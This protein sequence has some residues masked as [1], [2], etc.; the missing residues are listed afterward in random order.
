MRLKGLM[1]SLNLKS[2]DFEFYRF[3][4]HEEYRIHKHRAADEYQRR[5]QVELSLIRHDANCFYVDGYC[6]VCR[7]VTKFRVGFTYPYQNTADGKP[8]PDWREHLNCVKCGF[9][10]RVRLVLHLLQD[11]VRPQA[12]ARIYVTEQN[13]PVFKWLQSRYPQIMGSEYLGDS[14]PWGAYCHG[15]RNENLIR[16]SFA[17]KSFDLILSFDVMEHAIDDLSALSECFRCL[18]PGGTLVFTAPCNLESA[19]NVVR[20]Q[21]RSDG[22]IEHLMSPPE[23]HVNPAD[24]ENGALCFR[25]FGWEVIGQL[26]SVGFHDAQVISAWSRDL[27]YLGGEQIVFVATKGTV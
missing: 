15:L 24:P 7:D 6:A 1:G 21:M 18:A 25:Y 12:N 13:T 22:T 2:T 19:S 17:D 11:V 9:T 10:N 5:E 14:L 26:K 27:A 8:I 16:L 4:S 3:R 20:A 23:Y